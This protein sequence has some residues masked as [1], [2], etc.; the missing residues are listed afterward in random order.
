MNDKLKR[1]RKL[2]KERADAINRKR[3]LIEGHER[4]IELP[5]VRTL[6]GRHGLTRT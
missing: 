1:R 2:T 6:P 3:D 4:S 5:R